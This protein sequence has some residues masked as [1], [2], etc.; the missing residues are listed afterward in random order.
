MPNETVA[1]QS[2]DGASSPT[3]RAPGR[4]PRATAEK[5]TDPRVDTPP[6]AFAEPTTD[7]SHAIAAAAQVNGWV[8]IRTINCPDGGRKFV[9]AKDL[10]TSHALRPALV[11]LT[12]DASGRVVHARRDV[13]RRTFTDERERMNGDSH[14]FDFADSVFRPA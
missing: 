14:G 13:A 7:E 4:T 11:V 3:R 8:L 1:K 12:A 6:P 10:S 5:R 2:T 9:Y